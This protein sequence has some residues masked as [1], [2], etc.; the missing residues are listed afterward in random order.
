LAE[1][2]ELTFRQVPNVQQSLVNS[3]EQ[4]AAR[5]RPHGVSRMAAGTA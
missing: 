4:R 2:F 3:R 5:K 1:E